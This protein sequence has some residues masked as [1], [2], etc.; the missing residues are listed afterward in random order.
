MHNTHFILE[1]CS[2]L[3]EATVMCM[4]DFANTLDSVDRD[5][6]GWIM[7]AMECPLIF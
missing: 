4:F 6:I 3:Q 7:T 1:Q 5:S 2:S